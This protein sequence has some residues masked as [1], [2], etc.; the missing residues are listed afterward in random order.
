MK[1][2]FLIQ[3]FEQQASQDKK[4]VDVGA[5]LFIGNLDPVRKSLLPVHSYMLYES[6]F[7]QLV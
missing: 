5:N 3:L 6:S 1:P 7:F 4:S 2:D